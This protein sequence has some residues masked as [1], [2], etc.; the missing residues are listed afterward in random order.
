M[1]KA[2]FV[3][4][5][6]CRALHVLPIIMRL[7][8]LPAL[9]SALQVPQ[10]FPSSTCRAAVSMK[11]SK[12][13]TSADAQAEAILDSWRTKLIEEPDE[14]VLARAPAASSVARAVRQSRDE[15]KLQA[16]VSALESVS[17]E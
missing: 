3:S 2:D 5:A 14:P 13:P 16:Q 1:S 9:S 17:V 4:M 15:A 11:A 12:D 8:L 7:L 6:G 10:L